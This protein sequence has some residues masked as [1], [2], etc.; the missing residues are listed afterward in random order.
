MNIDAVTIASIKEALE[1]TSLHEIIFHAQKAYP[2]ECCGFIL[3]NGS[4]QPAHNVVESLGDRSLTSENAFLIDSESWQIAQKRGSPIIG[5]YH[6]HTNGDPEM[7]PVDEKFLYW[8]NLCYVVIALI[9]TNPIT[10]RLYWWEKDKL[11]YI[12]VCA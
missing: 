3:E 7:S 11:Q 5:I 6:S 8:R 1:K 9:D 10:T 2:K 4:I 12:E